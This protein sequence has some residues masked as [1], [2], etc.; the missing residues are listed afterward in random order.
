MARNPLLPIAFAAAAVALPAST[1]LAQSPAPMPSPMM[2]PAIGPVVSLSVNEEVRSAPDMATVSTGVQ[3]RA[4]TAQEAMRLNAQQMNRLIEAVLKAGIE[5]K[6]VQTSG[7]NLNPQYDY[8]NR[9]GQTQPRFLGYEASNQVTVMVRRIDD[10]GTVIDRMVTA[11]ATNVNGPSFGIADN[12]PLLRQARE[13]AIR[14]AAERAQ[15]YA[16]QTG[17]RSARLLSISET[18][19]FRPPMPMMMMAAERA[20]P[21]MDKTRVEPGEMATGVTLSFQYMLEK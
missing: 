7:I 5:R 9:E 11:G 19:D 18:G 20:A 15:F 8:S 21:M 10:V 1:A 17:Y 6:D 16:Q 2:V 13:K 4:M 3:T 12:A 14:T